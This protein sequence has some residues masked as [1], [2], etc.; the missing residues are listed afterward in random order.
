MPSPQR[1]LDRA[2][3]ILQRHHVD[4]WDGAHCADAMVDAL[5]S[6][7]FVCRPGE[8]SRCP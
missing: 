4:E 1:T 6:G 7:A 8:P 3:Q 2:C 5:S